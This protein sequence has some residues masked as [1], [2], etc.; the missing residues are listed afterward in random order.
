MSRISGHKCDGPRCTKTADGAKL[1]VGW[2]TLSVN[3]KVPGRPEG[4]TAT[5]GDGFHLC[6]N[7]CLKM[8]AIERYKA[9]VEDGSEVGSHYMESRKKVA[10][11]G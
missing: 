7:K 2:L 9:A 10:K 4:E 11:D 6:S 3:A 8:L 1:P 5:N